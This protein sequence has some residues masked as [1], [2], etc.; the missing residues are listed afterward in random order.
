[1]APT[2]GNPV[3]R[4]SPLHGSVTVS[5]T[6]GVRGGTLVMPEAGATLVVP[7]L[8]V[9]HDVVVTMT[10]HAGNKVQYDFGPHGTQFRIPLVLTQSL[11]GVTGSLKGMA[12]GYYTD[13]DNPL[14]VSELSNVTF[15][16]PNNT[17][18]ALLWHFSGFIYM[19]GRSDRDDD[20]W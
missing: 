10:A 15:D 9:D 6:I 12:V 1:A 3:L 17:A 7:P 18:A 8:A 16:L 5:A 13:G 2:K 4:T 14:W 19:S 11:N 20:R